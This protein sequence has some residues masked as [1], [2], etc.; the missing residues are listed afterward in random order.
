MPWDRPELSGWDIIGMNHY[1]LA[2]ERRLFVA[3]VRG[4]NWIRSEG[5][6][7]EQVFNDLAQQA[8]HLS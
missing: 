4:K 3:M 7:E 8:D 1:S 5:P 6:D 2:G